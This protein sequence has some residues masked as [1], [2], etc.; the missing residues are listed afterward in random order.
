MVHLHE[1][2]VRS[3]MVVVPREAVQADED[4]L[5]LAL[6]SLIGGTRPAVSTAMVSQYLSVRFG[7]TTLDVDIHT[8]D[9]EDFVVRFRH[10]EDR[11]CVLA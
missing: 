6:V 4:A 11:N 2:Q 1:R 8:H 9:P 10:H 7:L 3:G 5:E